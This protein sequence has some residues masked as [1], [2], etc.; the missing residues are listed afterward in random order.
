M[1]TRHTKRSESRSDKASRKWVISLSIIVSFVVTINILFYY[2]SSFADIYLGKGK[3][4]ITQAENTENWSSIYYTND[5]TDS[6][7]IKEASNT[8]VEQIES[9][10]IVLLKNN[11]GALPL[12]NNKGVPLRITLLGRGAGNPVYG[13]S[14]SGSVDLSSAENLYTALDNQGFEINKT[15]Y[16]ELSKYGAYVKRNRMGNISII[17]KHPR[18]NIV[19]DKPAFSTYYI[20]EMPVSEYSTESIDSFYDYNDAAIIM[21]SRGGGEGGDLSQ[22]IKDF[23]ANYHE[24]QHQLELNKD[25]IDLLELAKEHFDKII[26]LINS[27]SAMELGVL[28]DD[29]EIDS[30]LWVGSPGQTGFK[31]VADILNGNITPSGRTADIY[32][33]D[34]TADPTFVNFGNFQYNNISSDNAIGNGY[35]VQYEEGIYIGYRYYETAAAENFIN[36]NESVV[37]PF[38]Y[39]LS[40][41]NFDW[42]IDN[43]K[44]GKINNEIT[45][46]VKVT[47]T[48]G[49]YSGKDVVQLYY[50]PPY[51]P[52]G[53]EKSDV[54]LAA[55]GK[56]KELAPGE[57]ET[58]EL[59][60]AVEDMASYDYINKKSWILE[61]GEYIISFRENSN[62]V[63]KNTE[64]PVY[65]VNKTIVYEGKNHRSSDKKDVTNQFDDVS[66]MFTNDKIDVK[67]RNM[68][69]RD[70]AGTFPTIP[71]GHDFEASKEIIANF[72]L[73]SVDTNLTSDAKWPITGQDSGL[74]LID[75]RGKDF[76]DPTWEPF[77]NQLDPEKIVKMIIDSAYNTTAIQ[78][79]GKPATVDL[80]GPAGISAF[81]G[82]TNGTAF[83]SEVVIASTFN[84]DLAFNMGNMIGNEALNFG[85]NGWYA[86]AVNLHR[87]PFAGRNFEYYSEDP[88]LSGEMAKNVVEGAAG[89]GVYTFLKH[90]VLNDQETN[91]NNTGLATWANE[92]AI[93][94]LYLKP[95]EM[96]VKEGKTS[97]SYIGNN[98]GEIMHK[99]IPAATGIMSSFNRIGSVWTGGSKNLMDTVLRGEWGYIGAAIS[100]F[101]LY[102][103]M[104]VNQGLA[105]GTDFNITFASQKSIQDSESAVAVNYIRRSAHRI[106][107]MIANSNAMNGIIPGTTIQYTLAPWHIILIILDIIVGLIFLTSIFKFFRLLKKKVAV[108]LGERSSGTEL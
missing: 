76:D 22:D 41:T 93:R 30:V 99:E 42:E 48:G 27:S 82:D 44:F 86:P 69:R 9:E 39:G 106:L 96:V 71:T 63:K 54:V 40:Y 74:D 73:Y 65:K 90:L 52:G 47:N 24:G 28:Q 3:V 78:D 72:Q 4:V 98:Q 62:T 45:V 38:G 80:D 81:M 108:S 70:F 89:K 31:A 26:V 77:L 105:A 61:E 6:D 53:I 58:L 23:D 11:E 36:Y 34:F 18:A 20:G 95:F 88:Y 79:L 13:G 94:E 25:E 19:M 64:R 1:S 15:V 46:T 67:A 10:G 57:S 37:Y 59:S 84:T 16:D 97:I 83:P 85:I 91:R 12:E 68:S 92:Q 55:F 102:P 103:H 17:Y 75:M 14:G 87:S 8:L 104:F 33:R 7:S 50:T 21:F 35:F 43:Y 107:Y 101:N 49:T 100:D 66:D 56:T 2:F 32:P 29:P 60:F 5:F 51:T